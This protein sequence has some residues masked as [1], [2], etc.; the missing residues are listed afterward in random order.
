MKVIFLIY[1]SSLW[2]TSKAM[3]DNKNYIVITTD[4]CHLRRINRNYI[5]KYNIYNCITFQHYW[6]GSRLSW[7]RDGLWTWRLF[8]ILILCSYDTRLVRGRTLW[9]VTD[10]NIM[11]EKLQNVYATRVQY[12]GTTVLF[13][14]IVYIYTYYV[15]I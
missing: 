6:F 12:I 7:C 10:P 14:Y 4:H 5:M 9:S 1:S 3:Y 13:S 2:V 8:E 15:G 11:S